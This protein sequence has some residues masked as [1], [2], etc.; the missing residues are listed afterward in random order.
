M[1]STLLCTLL[2]AAL[3]TFCCGA[4]YF[5]KP[6]IVA[7]SPKLLGE[8][9]DMVLKSGNVGLTRDQLIAAFRFIECQMRKDVSIYTRKMT[10]LPCQIERSHALHGYIIRKIRGKGALIGRGC[11]KVVTKAILYGPTPKVLAECLSDLTGKD[12]IKTL[13]KLRGAKGIAPYLGAV[14]RGQK[15][16]IFLEY[17][18]QGSLVSRFHYGP[19][20][21]EEEIFKIALD[22]TE[23]LKALHSRKLMHRDLHAGNVLLDITPEHCK[24][25]LV[26]FGKTL[27]LSHSKESI[28]QA[29]CAKNPPEVLIKPFSKMNRYRVD[30]YALGN[31]FYEMVWGKYPSWAEVYNVYSLNKYSFATKRKMYHKAVALYKIAK[32]RCIGKLQQ[33]KTNGVSL[34]R[35]ERFKCLIFDMIDFNS[36]HRPYVDTV[37]AVLRDDIVYSQ[38]KNLNEE[39]GDSLALPEE[40][41][42]CP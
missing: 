38:N 8:R 21:S 25:V 10:H 31:L 40:V 42:M 27:P 26:D 7:S 34:T 39:K 35:M 16:S 23:G 3:S 18:C 28:P 15:Y 14:K 41:E 4:E 9:A 2:F 37:L 30:I 17:F 33:K 22:I 19:P 29:A 5:E 32:G 20:L 1:R 12:E 13:K 6:S 11:H 24:A 36:K